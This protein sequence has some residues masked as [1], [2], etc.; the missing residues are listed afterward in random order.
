MPE[1]VTDGQSPEAAEGSGGFGDSSEAAAF[2][3]P[4][5]E[6]VAE[7]GEFGRHDSGWVWAKYWVWL[8]PAECSGMRVRVK[9]FWA[10]A[11]G[12]LE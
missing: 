2:G 12:G 10:N 11:T 5:Y 9:L 8:L 3:Q 6:A 1:Q 7:S 4:E